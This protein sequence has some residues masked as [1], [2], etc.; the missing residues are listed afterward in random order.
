MT[1]DGLEKLVREVSTK[2]AEAV[3]ETVDGMSGCVE[4]DGGGDYIYIDPK[5][6]SNVQER[7]N[8]AGEIVEDYRC[9]SLVDETWGMN[10]DKL[11]WTFWNH[12][13]NV[14]ED[15]ELT[16]HASVADVMNFLADCMKIEAEAFEKIAKGSK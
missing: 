5:D 15:S 4:N 1:Q 9:L 13:A 16:I 11:H 12:G 6:S 14:Y 3:E 8:G 7:D 2:V 10:A